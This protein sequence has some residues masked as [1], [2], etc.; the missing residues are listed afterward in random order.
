M[1][2]LPLGERL[3]ATASGTAVGCETWLPMN[4]KK[5]QDRVWLL[6]IKGK[7]G[8][9]LFEILHRLFGFGHISDISDCAVPCL[10]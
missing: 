5:G 1:R 2:R 9:N 7:K 6:G 10:V 8:E 4:S 3:E